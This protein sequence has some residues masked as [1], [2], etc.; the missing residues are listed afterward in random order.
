MSED[1]KD[2]AELVTPPE[3]T[4]N[5]QEATPEL[6]Q[7]IAQVIAEVP[8]SKADTVPLS[9]FLETKKETKELKQAI[10]DLQDSANRGATTKEV[11]KDIA[12]LG[13]KFGVDADFLAELSDVIRAGAKEEAELAVKPIKEKERA[14]AIEKAFSKAYSQAMET[15][16]EYKEIVNANVIKMLSLD[17]SNANKTFPQLIEETYG[18]AV[19]GKRTIES[20]TPG[21]GKEPA[22]LDYNRATQDSA[23]F[24]E[25]M[26]N[27]K[28]K[29]EYNAI[30]LKTGF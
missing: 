28:L 19:G 4:E 9:V 23:Y 6:E 5:T 18:N 2:N 7:T 15:M 13:E 1:Q 21:G 25:V 12:S 27:P 17:P 3:T 10:K 22:P 14:D 20:T 11:S 26:A 30:M 24:K 16:P 8:E 29:A